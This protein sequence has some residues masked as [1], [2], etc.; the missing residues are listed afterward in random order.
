[1]KRFFDILLIILTI[2]I[3]SFIVFNSNLILGNYKFS[4]FWMEF[5]WKIIFYGILF[6]LFYLLF[7]W[8]LVRF[9]FVFNSSKENK[10]NKKIIELQEEL[11]KNFS[12][13]KQEIKKIF[14]ES[15]KKFFLEKNKEIYEKLWFI[16]DELWKINSQIGYLKD[17]KE[18]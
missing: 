18:K 10:L 4:L 13:E 8:I 1:M 11:N 9:V 12:E 14:E 6:F 7:S 3:V 15:C 2:F 16:D 17:K 5:E